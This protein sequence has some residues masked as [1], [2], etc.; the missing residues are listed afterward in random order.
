[1][2]DKDYFPIHGTASRRSFLYAA[3]SSPPLY[4]LVL[5][6]TSNR[7]NAFYPL[8]TCIVTPCPGRKK[9]TSGSGTR[10][11]QYRSNRKKIAERRRT[12]GERG[13]G[14]GVARRASCGFRLYPGNGPVSRSLR[15]LTSAI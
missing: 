6:N 3:R 9:C 15:C 14:M 7:R 8:H 10:P 1:M 11:R 2:K 12:K 5:R 4:F 13:N